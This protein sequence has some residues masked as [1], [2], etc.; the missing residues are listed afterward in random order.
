MSEPVI[1]MLMRRSPRERGLMA[2]LVLG[3]L[4]LALVLGWLLPLQERHAAALRGL[5]EAAALQEWVVARIR[6]RPADAAVTAPAPA[7]PIGS[8][9]IEQ[10]LIDSHLRGAVD[11]LASRAGGVVELRFEAVDFVQLANWLSALLPG[12]GYELAA[13]RFE[14][15]EAPGKVRAG[16][17]LKPLE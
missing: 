16:L 1:D 17:T 11:E 14:A 6:E 12:S 3:V 15:V 13:F 7:A 4:P 9:G 8:S 2:V 10:S 5:D